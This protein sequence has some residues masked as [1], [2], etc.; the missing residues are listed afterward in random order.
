MDQVLRDHPTSA[1]AHYVEAE[2]SA[3]AGI[4]PA[5][6]RN[7]RRRS[8]WTPAALTRSPSPWRRYSESWLVDSPRG[9]TGLLSSRSEG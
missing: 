3:R 4:S 9:P 2:L 5:A 8:D 7:W 6:G 1:K